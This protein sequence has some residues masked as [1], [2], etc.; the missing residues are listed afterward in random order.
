M[1]DLET[2]PNQLDLNY[3]CYEPFGM[4]DFSSEPDII[5]D[6]F[7]PCL[8]ELDDILR[9]ELEGNFGSKL[10]ILSKNIYRYIDLNF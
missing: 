5:G 8:Q 1:E 6:R 9:N 4:D 3:T 2:R 10:F 7:R